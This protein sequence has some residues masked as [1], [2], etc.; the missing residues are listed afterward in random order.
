[1]I[2]TRPFSAPTSTQG[3]TGSWPCG[4]VPSPRHHRCGGSRAAGARGSRLSAWRA[5]SVRYPSY[6]V[7]PTRSVARSWQRRRREDQQG[8]EDLRRALD[9]ARP[10]ARRSPA[11]QLRRPRPRP[12]GYVVRAQ[13][14]LAA[15]LL[16]ARVGHPLPPRVTRAGRYPRRHRRATIRGRAADAAHSN[17]MIADSVLRQFAASMLASRI[18]T[19]TTPPNLACAPG[20]GV[21]SVT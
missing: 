2:S 13:R 3:A 11:G 8:R 18:G 14:A 21:Y 12:L 7:T 16:A 17:K 5:R 4:A 6:L 10:S 15:R 19:C 1:M 9:E 20:L